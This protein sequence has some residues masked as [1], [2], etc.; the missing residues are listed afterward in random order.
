MFIICVIAVIIGAFLDGTS[1]WPLKAC[2][3]CGFEHVLLLSMS[4]GLLLLPWVVMFII[5]D[6]PS[7][8][9]LVGWKT[10][11]VSNLLSMSWG[12]ANVLCTV[13]MVKIGFVM[14]SV[15]LGGTALIVS[16]LLPFVVKGTGA[17]SN[18]PSILSQDGIITV[19]CVILMV[20]SITLISKAGELR[21][22]QL[23]IKGVSGE[24]LSQF[25]SNMYKFLTI[26]AG[27]L[28]TGIVLINTYCGD[29]IISA[30]NKTG[31]TT[32][33]NA[34][35][36]WAIGMFVGVMINI[37][38][39]LCMM[40]KN[41][42][43]GAMR[44]IKEVLWCFIAGLQFQVYMTVFAFVTPLMGALGAVIGN[45]VGA[46]VQT[47]GQ[48][49]IGFVFGEWRGV[50]GKPVKILVIGLILLFIGIIILSFK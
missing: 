14:V 24:N 50:K 42:S 23:G 27:A 12:I 47:A 13:C 43:F 29:Q 33:I 6:V 48:Q 40:V 16:T 25:K 15:L 18:A 32:P 49:F 30:M 38:Y 44:N 10:I 2:K 9:R 39:A 35:S 4:F 3:T 28:S 7:V 19:F 37:I 46:C 45:G 20:V 1:A 8:I 31:A 34:I 11:I 21:D 5:S 36:V 22:K 17:F 26:V 41:K